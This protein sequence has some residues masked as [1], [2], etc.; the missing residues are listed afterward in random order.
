VEFIRNKLCL[1]MTEQEACASLTAEIER[2][3]NTTAR[4]IDDLIHDNVHF[5]K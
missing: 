2:S 5:D 3:L 4:I 1:K